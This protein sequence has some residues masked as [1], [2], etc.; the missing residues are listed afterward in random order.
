MVFLVSALIALAFCVTVPTRFREDAGT[1]YKAFY[2]PVAENILRGSGVVLDAGKPAV[3]YPPGYSM[4][5]AWGFWVSSPLGISRDSAVIVM[6]VLSLGIVNML[7][8]LGCSHFWG[9]RGGLLVV[10]LWATYPLNLF[11][12]V[13][14]SP[15]IPFELF[16]YAALLVFYWSLRRSR[17]QWAPFLA[18][19]ILVGCAML[20]RP[21]ALFL[22][23]ALG[24]CLLWIKSCLPWG[25]RLGFAAVILVSAFLTI[26]PWEIRIYRQT[27]RVVLLGTLGVS[28]LK[29][30]LT[31]GASGRASRHGV[32]L[33]KDV[34][35]VMV[36]IK[37]RAGDI[38]TYADVTKVLGDQTR[39]RPMAVLK[40]FAIKIARSWYGTDSQRW[41]TPIAIVQALYLA[42]VLWAS[43][44]AWRAGGDQRQLASGVWIIVLYFWAMNVMSATTARY[45]APTMALLFALVPA[46]LVRL[47]G[48]SPLGV[49]SAASA[50]LGSPAGPSTLCGDSREPISQNGSRVS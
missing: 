35:E 25:K 41:E 21:I 48:F 12:C 26:L 8:F 34:R 37:S 27:G 43:V 31:F 16:L 9:T 17:H 38:K 39:K 29:D 23:V 10:F 1:D 20:I 6:N 46:L 49:P 15:E 2:K 18:C 45:A 36:D 30:G 28:A 14:P 3:R 50:G 5:L 47:R 11:F 7:V 44:R 32:A 42:L 4:L 13:Y 19:G 24:I 22:S 33:P 40:L